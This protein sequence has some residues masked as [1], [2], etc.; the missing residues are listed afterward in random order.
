MSL[1]IK[2]LDKAQ[3]EK[4]Q[5]SKDK[6]SKK[7]GAKA[8]AEKP[9]KKKAVPA[10]ALSLEEPNKAASATPA[11]SVKPTS[12]DVPEALK[13]SAADS[14]QQKTPKDTQALGL[15]PSTKVTPKK[16]VEQ[17]TNAPAQ[18]Q[19]ANV[20]TA[21]NTEPSHKTAKVAIILGLLALVLLGALAYWY[22]TV[23]NTPDIVIPPR[24]AVTQGMPKPMPEAAAENNLPIVNE[25]ESMD[26]EAVTLEMIDAADAEVESGNQTAIMQEPL[27]ETELQENVAQPLDTGQTTTSVFKSTTPSGGVEKPAVEETLADN[28]T[29]VAA[30]AVTS[31]DGQLDLG[32]DE[33]K[34]SII[35]T[36]KKVESGVTPVLMRAYEAY[37]AGNDLQ[38]QQDYKEVLKR[39]GPSVDAMLGLGAIATRQGRLADAHGWYRKVLEVE[40][41]NEVARAGLL[42]LQ[43]SQDNPPQ[44]NESNLK[45]MIASAPND[46]NLHAALGDVYANQN[47][48]AAA[49]QAYFDAYRLSQSAENAFN[50]AV[51]LD[52]LSKPV[53]ALP[54]Y[55]EALQKAASSNVI[56]V[57]ALKARISSIE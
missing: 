53:L 26:T 50:L 56:D 23:F 45:S 44:A 12:D 35:I 46:A 33:E 10:E 22:Q 30:D 3:A 21:K 5:A 41:R 48:W 47:Q 20:F 28:E 8:K 18:A 6:A 4:A 14:A 52:Q 9:A 1:L 29:V 31:N 15:S 16:T 25:P 37:N 2:A 32:A 40:P 55:R 34:S 38:A 17:P 57:D 39:Y 54:Y 24:P 51:S 36:P 27:T 19:A 13:G 43:Q 11:P 42:S 49:Q 7:T